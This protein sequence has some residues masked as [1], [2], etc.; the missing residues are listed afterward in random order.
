ME[1]FNKNQLINAVRTDIIGELEA[2]DQYQAHIDS[3]DSQIAIKVWT[4]IRNEEMVH[5][6]ELLTLLAVLDPKM[7]DGIEK[8][9]AEVRQ[10]MEES[11]LSEN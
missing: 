4:D 9:E 6:G 11:N 8:G 2:I 3:T 10:M 7:A 1:K 5:V